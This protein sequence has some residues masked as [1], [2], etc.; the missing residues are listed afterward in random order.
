MW[1]RVASAFFIVDFE[2]ASFSPTFDMHLQAL[3]PSGAPM[4]FTLS[5]AS[6]SLALTHA[7]GQVLALLQALSSCDALRAP[8]GSPWRELPPV[9]ALLDIA[10]RAALSGASTTSLGCQDWKEAVCCYFDEL[11]TAYR[12]SAKDIASLVVVSEP[13]PRIFCLSVASQFLLGAMFL[14]AQEYYECPSD[15]IRLHRFT[16]EDYKAWCRSCGGFR[17]YMTWPGFNVPSWVVQDMRGG[18][19]GELEQQEQALLSL[20]PEDASEPFYIIGTMHD[21]TSTLRHEL[22]HGLFA[23]CQAYCDEVTGILSRLE[24]NET[25]HLQ[26]QLLHRGY[27]NVPKIIADEMQAY[28]SEGET[29][30]SCRADLQV[31]VSECFDKHVSLLSS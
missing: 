6:M 31:A 11:M 30:G 17:Y 2:V 27:P 4:S 21:D 29:L 20:L 23:T 28:F 16:L 26:Q 7:V 25:C 1:S 10:T 8:R 14:R 13:L 22:A 5:I 12:P 3:G 18:L 15:D 9:A 19:L 24:P